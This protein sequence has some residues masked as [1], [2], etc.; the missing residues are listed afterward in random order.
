MP[1]MHSGVIQCLRFV[2]PSCC[3]HGIHKFTLEYHILDFFRSL[4][5]HSHDSVFCRTI[6]IEEIV[7]EERILGKNLYILFIQEIWNGP[8]AIWTFHFSVIF[9]FTS[10]SFA[11]VFCFSSSILFFSFSRVSTFSCSL[12]IFRLKQKASTAIT[13]IA[14]RTTQ[15]TLDIRIT[16]IFLNVL[17]FISE[18]YTNYTIEI[19]ILQVFM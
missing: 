2:F 13:T 7:F 15:I 5:N 17:P 3:F 9:W 10:S 6:R 19:I 11:T 18:R 8:L 16:S 1:E 12:W 14:T 4:V